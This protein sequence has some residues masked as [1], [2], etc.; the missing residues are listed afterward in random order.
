MLSR[1]LL[2]FLFFVQT[3]SLPVLTD[4]KSQATKTDGE[5]LLVRQRSNQETPIRMA[6]DR[7]VNEL[8]KGVAEM[9][10]ETV[11]NNKQLLDAKKEIAALKN[12]NSALKAEW[13]FQSNVTTLLS[14]K[15]KTTMNSLKQ[16]QD[17]QRELSSAVSSLQAL[18][19]NV[20]L[21]AVKDTP[22]AFTAGITSSSDSWSGDI[23]VFPHVITNKGQG[24]DN[25]TGKFT[26]P[27]DGTY[28]FTL[29]AVSY[30]DNVI[31]LDIVHDGVRKV[32]TDST[33]FSRYQTGTNLVVLELDRGDAVWVKRYNG[34]G[35]W[36]HSVPL[37]TFSGFLL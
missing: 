2:V 24:Y 13:Q 31:N 15:L 37:T 19:K 21:S 26:A 27:R 17:S 33:G 8:V 6:L 9:I 14:D 3:N 10:M 1:L 7:K 23:L 4:E 29:T 28:I 12:E 35:Y 5:T 32:R 22:V 25:S 30:N 20:S 11:T 16:S 34:Q 18:Q 36:T